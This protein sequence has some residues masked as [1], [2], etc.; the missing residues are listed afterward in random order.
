M[1]R[2]DGDFMAR[3]AKPLQTTV[4]PEQLRARLQE[5]QSA[6]LHRA[7]N[8]IRKAIEYKESRNGQDTSNS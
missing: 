2:D 7:S 4:A 5:C 3:F 8:A 1:K 6:K